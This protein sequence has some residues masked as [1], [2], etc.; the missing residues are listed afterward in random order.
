MA[1]LG[2]GNRGVAQLVRNTQTG[3][4]VVRKASDPPNRAPP[5]F[6]LSTDLEASVTDYLASGFPNEGPRPNIAELLG[7]SIV[8]YPS[9]GPTGCDKISHVTYWKYYNL[10]QLLSFLTAWSGAGKKTFEIHGFALV[11]RF[12]HQTLNALAYMYSRGIE[13][14][15][16]HNRNIFV[17]LEPGSDLPDFYIG[18]FDHARVSSTLAKE[19]H[20]DN[21]GSRSD[22]HELSTNIETLMFYANS[23][24][25]AKGEQCP[26]LWNIRDELHQL[27]DYFDA[28][29]GSIRRLAEPG[30]LIALAQR[31]MEAEKRYLAKQL[32]RAGPSPCVP[33]SSTRQPCLWRE[34]TLMSNQFE[35][36]V[37]PWHIARMDLKTYRVLEVE[38]ETYLHTAQLRWNSDSEASCGGPG[39]DDDDFDAFDQHEAGVY[40][41]GPDE[42]MRD[43]RYFRDGGFDFE[44]DRR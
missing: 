24:K 35:P 6:P 18:D 10:G 44:K 39:D 26:E 38:H 16:L 33:A 40:D 12:A 5:G 42:D 22:L 32:R 3:E 17:H 9:T 36:V 23:C 41:S 28:Q 4:L 29:K 19:Q 20:N 7:Y 27:A 8:R 11:A 25:P 43:W 37:G 30:D 13:H 31:A 2:R 34:E 21:F 1:D 15:D 14:G